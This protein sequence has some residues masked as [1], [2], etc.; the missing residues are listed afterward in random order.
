M[1]EM[2][3]EGLVVKTENNL[4]QKYYKSKAA[5]KKKTITTWWDKGFLTSSATTQLKKLMG[6]KV[7]NN[8]KNVNFLRRI[9]ELWTTENDIV[10]DFFGGSGTT[11]QGV[12]ELNK[13]DGLNRKFILCEQLD[14]V[15]AV[16]VKRINRVIEQLK[17][18]SSFTYL[19]LAK[20]NQTAKEEI[21]NCK[22]LEELL[23]FFETMY[24]KYFLHYNVRIK[25]FKE[26]I[27]QE[28]NFK[29]LALERQ[30][31]IF[32]KMLDLNQL[33]V[34]LSEIEDS[35]YKLDAKDIAL[36]KDFYQVKN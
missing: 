10:L 11:A 32:S 31:E 8:P 6:D 25:Q 23:K 15:N 5:S 33:Y 36:S 30:K 24:T 1:R 7:F 35:R 26:V 29:N 4:Q 9:I 3:D 22:N 14:Y 16:T 28:E 12:L 17:S 27:S 34:N 19:E 2:F 13:E 21:L 20:N 18:N